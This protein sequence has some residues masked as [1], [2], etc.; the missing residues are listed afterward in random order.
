MSN[1]CYLT[2]N[3]AIRY[4]S[5]HTLSPI[6][7]TRR[8]LRGYKGEKGKPSNQARSIA[9]SLAEQVW[10][11][12]DSSPILVIYPKPA[13]QCLIAIDLPCGYSF[14]ASTRFKHSGILRSSPAVQFPK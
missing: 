12:S 5:P 3:S 4:T 2:R 6:D 9:R 14:T 1:K 8:G 11:T 13:H 10:S 7:V